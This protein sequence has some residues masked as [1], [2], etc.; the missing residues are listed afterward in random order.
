MQIFLNLA[1]ENLYCKLNLRRYLCPLEEELGCKKTVT[2]KDILM[3]HANNH[4]RAVSM[5]ANYAARGFLVYYVRANASIPT[6]FSSVN[7]KRNS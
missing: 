4:R 7:K 3:A 1:V 5:R 2:R 6:I